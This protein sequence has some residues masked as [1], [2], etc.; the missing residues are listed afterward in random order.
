M[1][2]YSRV[3]H[4]PWIIE[5]SGVFLIPQPQGFQGEN[6]HKR[7][8]GFQRGSG[9]RERSSPWQA[10]TACSLRTHLE[11]WPGPRAC[12][13]G[14]RFC[15]RPRARE[16]GPAPASLC[17]RVPTE[18]IK[19]PAE[20]CVALT[21]APWE[22][23]RRGVRFSSLSSPNLQRAVQNRTMGKLGAGDV[24]GVH[25]KKR[26]RK[27][28]GDRE[29]GRR[30]RGPPPTPRPTPH[31]SARLSRAVNPGASAPPS[32]Q[33]KKCGP[34]VKARARI[35]RRL[36]APPRA[37]EQ[38]VCLLLPPPGGAR[39][40]R[41]RA[42]LRSGLGR[43]RES[44]RGNCASADSRPR[45]EPGDWCQEAAATRNLGESRESDGGGC[46]A[47]WEVRVDL[48]SAVVFL[49]CLFSTLTTLKKRACERR[50][51]IQ[52]VPGLWTILFFP[53]VRAWIT[54]PQALRYKRITWDLDK[55]QIHVQ[56][57]WRSAFLM[58]SRKTLALLGGEGL[59]GNSRCCLRDG[60]LLHCQ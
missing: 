49:P 38:R 36:H 43:A 21:P 47:A 30:R 52:D 46:A 17:P 33:A 55:M 29:R 42:S 59:A 19:A 12:N 51:T 4:R 56:Q 16:V 20:P 44:P 41:S 27:D 48:S 24:R 25:I 3:P 53:S 6:D 45:S 10:S 5:G 31:H 13:L 26:Q 23:T 35:P 54:V 18:S 28:R 22:R 40:P 37:G 14:V 8:P 60:L 15:G 2:L 9:K 57:P 11:R 1:T 39:A 32:E 58:S 7:P 34:A 50:G